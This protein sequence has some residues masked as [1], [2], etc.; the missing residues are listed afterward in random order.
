MSREATWKQGPFV[1]PTREVGSLDEDALREFYADGYRRLTG[2]LA[3]WH[4]R[5]WAEDLVQDA[6]LRAWERAREGDEPASLP[7]WVTTVATNLA[8]SGLRR[9]Q[10]EQRALQRLLVSRPEWLMGRVDGPEHPAGDVADLLA[11]LPPRQQQVLAL[12][13]VADLDHASI[14]ELLGVDVGT[15]KSTLSRGR[16]AVERALPERD[17]P[18][19]P[20]ETT[21]TRI[22]HWMMTG[23]APHDYELGLDGE[24]HEGAR[25]ALLRAQVER[26]QGFGGICQV[27][28]ADDYRGRRVRFA[29]RLRASDVTDWAGLWM[30]VDGSRSQEPLAFDNMEDRP[31]RGS[32]GWERVAIVLDVAPEAEAI[33]LGALLSGAGALRLCGLGFEEVGL[34]VPVTGPELSR[35]RHPVNLDFSELAE[36]EG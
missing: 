17:R 20:K 13:Y 32:T 10:A 23:A 18:P 15:V 28:S 25:V 9:Q 34:E 35:P 14:A 4:S 36:G 22:K 21:V 27:I 5:A 6:L 16:R 33:Y 30:R 19:T 24:R 7:A 3:G 26:P 29:A 1:N 11:G 2:R 31:L 8:R 12:R